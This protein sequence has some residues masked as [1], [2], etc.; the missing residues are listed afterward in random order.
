MRLIPTAAATR[1]T[2][3]SGRVP[4]T[5]VRNVFSNWLVLGANVVYA[6][7]IT[8]VVVRALD[9]E[10]YGVWSYLNGL[11]TYSELLYVGLGSALIK[12]VA[13][14][15]ARGESQ[16][17]NEVFSAVLSMYALLGTACFVLLA[18]LSQ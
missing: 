2:E 7:L 16:R 6:M 13:Q 9:K 4:K 17:V 8:P 1:L 12:Y 10:L 15:R 5:V 14:Y 18:A 11:L 3:D